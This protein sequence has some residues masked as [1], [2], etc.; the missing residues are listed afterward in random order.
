MW[1]RPRRPLY[2]G[3]R[4]RELRASPYSG[5][6]V[7]RYPRRAVRPGVTLCVHPSLSGALRGRGR[8]PRRRR[9][10]ARR[11][12]RAA[13]ADVATRLWWLL[14]YFGHDDTSV[15]DGG[16]AAWRAADGPVEPGES[17]Y[18]PAS[19]TACPRARAPRQPGRPPRDH[20]EWLCLPGQRP[21]PPKRSA[22]RAPVPTAARAASRTASTC[23]GTA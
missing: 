10:H 13:H 15:L 1:Y 20:R 21:V 18:P 14:R 19:F 7:R 12:V 8:P 23:R 6:R 9:R 3:E 5:G 17:A 16:L 2:R 22:A 4:A 11:R